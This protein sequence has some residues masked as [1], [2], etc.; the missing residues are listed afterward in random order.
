MPKFRY[1]AADRTGKT[2]RGEMETPDEQELFETLKGENR[3]LISAEEILPKRSTRK[4][5][6]LALADFSREL[7]TLLGAG[8]PL[9]RALSI[10]SRSE[11]LKQKERAVYIELVRQIRQGKALSDAMESMKDSF[12]PLMIH[13]F[14]ASEKAGT[15]GQTALRMADY[16]TKEHRINE[17]LKSSM[18][19]PQFL[20]VLMVAVV[21]ILLGYVLPQFESLFAMMEEL[22]LPTRI[23][24]GI[25][26][27]FRRY[28]YL[29]VILAAAGAAGWSVIRSA[30]SVRLMR[31][32]LRVQMPVV[33]KL[34]KTIYTTRF[35]RTLSSLYA[36]GIPMI[37]AMQIAKDS[38][39]NFY[40]E[41]Q[42]E[43]AIL[44]V[45][46]GGTLSEAI[47]HV[48]GFVR[49]LDYGIRVGEETGSLDVMLDAIADDLEYESH[50]AVS[51]MLIYLEPVMIVIL[52]V[53]VG[54]IMI[55]VMMPIYESYL[56]MESSVYQ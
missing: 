23:L 37:T 36:A 32:R 52:A 44:I 33:G 38:V 25:A 4:L 50:Q 30:D 7:G 2:V 31:G 21:A 1:T 28:W 18:A 17:K 45:R 12:P 39:G 13:M 24:Y 40:L 42:L 15:M 46:A 43:T 34:W 53:I 27:F 19:Y 48:D 54:F 49:K 26:G 5:K 11:S 47:E 3:Y 6:A 22:P 41:K 10:I 14:R 16:Y 29:A 56:V 35:A 51:N 20:A 8:V 55:A 9:L